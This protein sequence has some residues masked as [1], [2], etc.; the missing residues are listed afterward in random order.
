MD[1][2]KDVLVGNMCLS[3][4]SPSLVDVVIITIYRYVPSLP[5]IF[6]FLDSREIRAHYQQQD[7][8]Q[9]TKFA[10]ESNNIKGEPLVDPQEGAD[11]TTAHQMNPYETNFHN[12]R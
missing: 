10:V 6:V 5:A 8:P 11:A 7:W 3:L 12:S 9:R 4:P 1:V 2:P